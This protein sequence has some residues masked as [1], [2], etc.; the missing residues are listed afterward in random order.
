MIF[1][2]KTNTFK[3]IINKRIG[4]Y[5]CNDYLNNSLR[6][7][8]REEPTDNV[9]FAISEIIYCVKTADGYFAEDV[10]KTLKERG[11]IK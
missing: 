7:L 10:K 11:Y 1:N 9:V 2:K 8:L 3:S 5:P 4:V 6:Y